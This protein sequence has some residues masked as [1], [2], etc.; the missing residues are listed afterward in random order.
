MHNQAIELYKQAMLHAYHT[1]EPNAAHPFTHEFQA[2][3]AA[4]HSEL[5]IGECIGLG[6]TIKPNI[7]ASSEYARGVAEGIKLYETSIKRHFGIAL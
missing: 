3:V 2:I 4:T 5:L 6:A 7:A 1:S